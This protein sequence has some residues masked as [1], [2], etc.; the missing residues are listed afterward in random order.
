MD[1]NE[2][3]RRTLEQYRADR[4]H[5]AEAVCKTIV[6]CFSPES[7]IPVHKLASGFGGGIG[8]S[9]GE[10]CGALTGGIVAL[11]WLYGRANPE[12][13]KTKVLALSGEL[14]RGFIEKYGTTNCQQLLEQFV[15]QVEGQKCKKLTADTAGMLFDLVQRT[16]QSQS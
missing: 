1:R 14:R 15:G 8:A 12:D 11:G 3:E 10:T 5:C 16:N 9:H 13:D 7:R 6:E 4:F 2:V